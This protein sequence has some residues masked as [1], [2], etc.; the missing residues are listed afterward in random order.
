[1][2]NDCPKVAS[3]LARTSSSKAKSLVMSPSLL[4]ESVVPL[5]SLSRVCKGRLSLPLKD[6]L[7]KSKKAWP[8]VF[9]LVRVVLLSRSIERSV[10]P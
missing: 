1:M 6:F 3:T 10:G 5:I 8:I 2:L 4:T 7:Y 9:S